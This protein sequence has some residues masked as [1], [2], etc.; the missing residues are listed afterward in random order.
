MRAR[1]SVAIH[2][3][4]FLLADEA[5]DEPPRALTAS[6]RAA[7]LPGDS[8]ITLQHGALLQ[9]A[10]GRLL[11]RPPTLGPSPASREASA[12]SQGGVGEFPKQACAG[13]RLLGHP[14]EE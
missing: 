13:N 10:G 9:A 14:H 4:T 11:N 2:C 12:A 7:G 3:C 6:L 8:F 5:L 1:T